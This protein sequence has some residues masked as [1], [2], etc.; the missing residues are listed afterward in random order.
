MIIIDYICIT[1]WWYRYPSEKYESQLGWWNSHLNGK[2]KHVPNMSKPPTSG[3]PCGCHE[4]SPKNMWLGHIMVN[5]WSS[6]HSWQ[7][8]FH[9]HALID[10]GWPICNLDSACAHGWK[11]C[12]IWPGNLT[13][14]IEI[15]RKSN[16]HEIGLWK[17][18]YLPS[19]TLHL[20]ELAWSK[21]PAFP[22]S[23]F[24]PLDTPGLATGNSLWDAW[25][26]LDVQLS[27]ASG[28]CQAGRG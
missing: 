11:T 7:A 8:G 23:H 4:M 2:H 21:N 20:T 15:P 5:P 26:G 28:L 1:G 17:I 10:R 13:N 6:E 22:P 9:V 27:E 18:M 25:Y 24:Q 19:I 14:L 3:E 16:A 12:P